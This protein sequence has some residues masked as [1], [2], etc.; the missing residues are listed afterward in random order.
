MMTPEQI[1]EF[2]KELAEARKIVESMTPDE[3]RIRRVLTNLFDSVNTGPG[4]ETFETIADKIG[5][6][7]IKAFNDKY[8]WFP[9][10]KDWDPH[11]E[12][13]KQGRW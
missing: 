6:E 2:E 3:T 5:R 1:I 11:K 4:Y 10:L 7:K 8:K 12:Y 13:P 9:E